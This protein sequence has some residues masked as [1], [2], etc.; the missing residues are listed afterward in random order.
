M[1]KNS[2]LTGAEDCSSKSKIRSDYLLSVYLLKAV[3]NTAIP[4]STSSLVIHMGGLIRITYKE[5]KN[6][7]Y[8]SKD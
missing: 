3:L 8:T 1:L 5:N 7:C 4:K 2:L 6:I